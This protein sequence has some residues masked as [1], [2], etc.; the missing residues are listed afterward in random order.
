MALLVATVALMPVPTLLGVGRSFLAY[1]LLCAGCVMAAAWVLGVG[2]G[3]A[4]LRVRAG[5][6]SGWLK[7][8][9]VA[10]IVALAAARLG[11]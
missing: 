7:A 2:A 4:T 9:M 1:G 8:A 3:R 6:A 10:G 5:R 11:V